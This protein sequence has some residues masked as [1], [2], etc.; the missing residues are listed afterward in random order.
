MKSNFESI[1]EFIDEFFDDK[2]IRKK[3]E[4]LAFIILENHNIPWTWYKEKMLQLLL[5][6]MQ[7]GVTGAGSG[8]PMYFCDGDI[9][10]T[11]KQVKKEGKTHAMVCQIGM[12]L[13]G[14]GDQ[15]TAKTPIQNFYEFSESDQFMRAHILAWPGYPSKIHMQH[16][17][18]NLTKWNGKSVTHFGDSYTR[19]EDNIHDDYTPLWIDTEHHPR[20]HNFTPEQRQQ[21]WF[22]YPH[23]DY[24]KHEQKLYNYIQ[25]GERKLEGQ[26]SSS[27]V[28]IKG[29]YEKRRKRFYYENNEPLRAPNRKYDLIF[30]PTSGYIA[31][32]LYDR[33]SH[34]DTE[35]IIYDYDQLFL[36]TREKIISMGLTGK[37][38]EMYMKHLKN[39]NDDIYL[40][41][42]S[43]T[44]NQIRSIEYNKENITNTEELRDNLAAHN[45]EFVLCNLLE[46]DLSWIG[47]KAKNKSVHFYASNI[48]KYYVVALNYDYEQIKS[49]YNHLISQLEKSN[50]Y[51]F[52]G[53]S[54]K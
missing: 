48:F 27:E 44:P 40:F 43:R 38:L 35:V 7:G 45:P 34:K 28:I 13:C 1:N 54:Y 50:H 46:D 33:C 31:E 25:T 41:S 8:H 12:V 14:T 36:D 42:T 30:A 32:F 49:Q 29:L 47:E 26:H 24:E 23:R 51:V 6:N 22:T 20:I 11:L 19:S 39:T 15:V 2:I 16:F 5:W 37:D 18:I 53:T 3:Y 17:E 21:K 52:W 4:H 9:H 10:E